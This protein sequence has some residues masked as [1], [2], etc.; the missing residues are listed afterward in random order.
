[1]EFII[2]N[3]EIISFYFL[4]FFI[5]II[6]SDNDQNLVKLLEEDKDLFID[7]LKNLIKI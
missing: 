1:M 5:K 4:F 2:I 6:I 7:Y 3:L